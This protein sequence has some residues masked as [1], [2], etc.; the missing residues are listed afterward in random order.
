[1]W[2]ICFI[3]YFWP[4]LISSQILQFF[5][6]SPI[7]HLKMNIIKLQKYCSLC[8][9][10]FQLLYSYNCKYVCMWILKGVIA[11]LKTIE[12]FCLL[13][14]Y[15]IYQIQ[16]CKH[17]LTCKYILILT[18]MQIDK[19]RLWYVTSIA[20]LD[21][22]AYIICRKQ[23]TINEYIWNIYYVNGDGNICTV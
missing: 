3:K 14:S 4:Y 8:Y 17:C 10:F 12:G 19:H 11:S 7:S 15:P 9:I 21:P 1:M 5:G 22:H 18:Y 13:I 16:T 6:P 20:D 23:S 2:I